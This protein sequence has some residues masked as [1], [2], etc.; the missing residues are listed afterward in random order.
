MEGVTLVLLVP[1]PWEYQDKASWAVLGW[2]A[3]EEP[4]EPK[5]SHV[6]VLSPWLSCSLLGHLGPDPEI[7]RKEED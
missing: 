2:A 5:I 4:E 3:A 1:M 7:L 6:S